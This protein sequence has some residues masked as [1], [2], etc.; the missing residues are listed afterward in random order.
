MNSPFIVDAVFNISINDKELDLFGEQRPVPGG[1]SCNSY[2]ILDE[3]TAVIHPV[4]ERISDRWLAKLKQVMDGE[5]LDYLIVSHAEPGYAAAVK[6]FLKEYPEAKLAGNA[7]TIA[8]FGSEFEQE[9]QGR[10]H[11]VSEKSE[12][13]LGHHVLRFFMIPS[14]EHPE[15]MMIYEA[16]EQILFSSD[17]SGECGKWVEECLERTE[18]LPVQKVCPMYEVKQERGGMS[19]GMASGKESI[20]KR[21]AGFWKMF[22]GVRI[23]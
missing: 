10:I 3:R 12:L 17:K 7:V 2:V 19:G 4:S 1:V 6:T 18:D 16:M 14:E 13:E 15:I 21:K 11:L 23:G 22:S 9:F 20:G 5:P 8:A